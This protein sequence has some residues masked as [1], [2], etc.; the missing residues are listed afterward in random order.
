MKVKIV[1]FGPRVPYSSFVPGDFV[2]Y[3]NGEELDDKRV[4]LIAG[5][6]DNPKTVQI[7]GYTKNSEMKISG[8]VNFGSLSMCKLDVEIT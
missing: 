6:R 7:V 2:G 4:W 3:S 1:K 8:N 5:S